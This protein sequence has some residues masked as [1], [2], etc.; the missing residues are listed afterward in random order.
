M[1]SPAI[2]SL[3]NRH[4]SLSPTERLI[5]DGRVAETAQAA[6]AH[7]YRTVPDMPGLK[8]KESPENLSIRFGCHPMERE[9]PDDRTLWSGRLKH[10]AR[11]AV[12]VHGVQHQGL[13]STRGFMNAKKQCNQGR[14]AGQLHS[15][16][17]LMDMVGTPDS[18]P[19]LCIKV[20]VPRVVPR[21]F[22][23]PKDSQS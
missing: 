16:T 2:A 13:L 1:I 21:E 18:T 6:L 8:F 3:V 23:V 10:V 20:R 22:M 19:R 9:L 14:K 11:H 4:N 12:G 7:V 5:L 17:T 15:Q